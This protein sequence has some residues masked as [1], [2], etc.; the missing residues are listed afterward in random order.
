M[1]VLTPL[2]A[3]LLAPFVVPVARVLRWPVDSQ[4]RSRRNALVANNLLTSRRLEREDTERFLRS[5]TSGRITA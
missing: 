4:A 2:T 3:P 1:S 5:L